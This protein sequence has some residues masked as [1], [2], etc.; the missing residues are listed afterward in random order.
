MPEAR[1]LDEL[2]ILE[3]S[4]VDRPANLSDGW[5]VM[6]NDASA[7]VNQIGVAGTFFPATTT[8]HLQGGTV[9]TTGAGFTISPPP[10]PAP[11]VAKADKGPHAFK[12][13][14]DDPKVCAVCGES[15]AAGMHY[16]GFGKEVG[17][18][19]ADLEKEMS[20]MSPAAKKAAEALLSALKKEGPMPPDKAAIEKLDPDMQAHIAD[21]QAKADAAAAGPPAAD[22]PVAPVAPVAPAVE[23]APLAPDMVAMQKALDDEKTARAEETKKAADLAERVEKMEAKERTAE[24]VAKARDLPNLGGANELGGLLMDIS[25]KV[26]EATYKNLERLLKAANAQ[27]EKGALFGV[28]GDPGAEPADDDSFDAKVTELAKAKVAAGTSKT[29]EQAKLD[30]LREDP[31]LRSQY[32][33]R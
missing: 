7:S 17:P 29:I 10:P 14:A 28:R 3:S 12:P 18:L 26:E 32:R 20:T 13:S 2:K 11:P 4:G 1:R 16:H 24:F 9:Y 23:P 22:P 33:A 30:V 19:A 6:K 25:G 31:Q 5:L 15:K 8:G 27:L 21:L